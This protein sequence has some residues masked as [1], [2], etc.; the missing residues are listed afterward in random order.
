MTDGWSGAY[1]RKSFDNYIKG[2]VERSAVMNGS[3]ALLMLDIDNFKAIN[4]TYGHNTG[5]RVLMAFANKCREHI[6]DEDFFA[7]YGGEEFVIVMP[8]ASLRS[9]SKRAKQVCKA[10]A[11]AR[12]ALENEQPGDVLRITTSIGVGSRKKGDSATSII[13]RAD[14]ALYMAKQTGKNRVVTEKKI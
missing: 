5:D 14:K 9:A 13:Q 1:N 12:Y 7:R 3:F 11:T 8:G 2:L 10:I 4:D 6:R